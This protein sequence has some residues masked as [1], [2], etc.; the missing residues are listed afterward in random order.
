MGEDL[1]QE[2]IRLKK[3]NQILKIII[4]ELND[5]I[6][7]MSYCGIVDNPKKDLLRILKKGDKNE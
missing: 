4:N 2:N 5:Y 1:H 6:E 7:K 3:E